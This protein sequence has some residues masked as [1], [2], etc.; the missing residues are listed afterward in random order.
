MNYRYVK[1]Q[2]RI[3]IHRADEGSQR[4]MSVDSMHVYKIL[5]NANCSVVTESRS[6]FNAWG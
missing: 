5:K 4:K 6:V 2:R 1:Q 3:K